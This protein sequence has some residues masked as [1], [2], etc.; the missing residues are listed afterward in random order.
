MKG[1]IRIAAV[2]TGPATKGKDSLV[3]CVIMRGGVIEGVLSTSAMTDGTDSTRK[4]ISMIRRSRFREQVK[5][6]ALNGIAIAGLN[7]VDIRRAAKSLK[8]DFA[9]LTRHR[10]RKALLLKALKSLSEQTG[11]DTEER[12]KIVKEM[13]GLEFAKVGG[14]FVQ[15]SAE[16][17]ENLATL[18]FEALRISH[19]VARG[20]ATGE[21]KGRV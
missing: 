8:V 18:V 17:T 12:V 13:A 6:I 5:L 11:T 2:A 19:L 1:G 7:V 14:F 4:I 15:S 9:V 20:V 3:V 21:S 10:P 16:V